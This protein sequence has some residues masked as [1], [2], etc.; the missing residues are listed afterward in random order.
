M[1]WVLIAVLI[2]IAIAFIFPALLRKEIVQD[3]TREQNIAIAREQLEELEQRYKQNEIDQ[4]NYQSVKEELEH[5]LF[6]D[7]KESDL[8]DLDNPNSFSYNKSKKVP[9]KSVDTWLIL[10]LA[11]V[12]A[13]P[14]YL[15]LGNL[16]F[17]KYLDAKKAVVDVSKSSMPLKADGSPDV[18][19]I[20]R[21]LKKEMESNPTDPKGWYM[22]GR[23]YMM[24]NSIPDAVDSF[25][26]SL[27]LRP[28]SA[29]TMLSLADALSMDNEGQLTGKPRELVKKA[30]TIEPQNVTALWL[31]GMAASQE[32]EYQEAI[33]QWQKV[34]PFIDN[35]PEEKNA[36]LGLIEEAQ[37][38]LGDN[39]TNQ[40]TENINDQIKEEASKNNNKS[41]K[42]KITLS[43][44]FTEKVSP[45]DLVF[46]YAKAMNGPPMPLAAAR[47][48]VKEFPIDLI[49]NDEMAMIPNMKLSSYEMVIVGARISKSG[50][51]IASDG[52]LF[53]EKTNISL[54]DSISLEIDQIYKK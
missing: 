49:L 38:R 27:A 2:A 37:K 45:E 24:I 7:I 23:A 19:K 44:E 32:A 11:P 10:I 36:V 48:L 53:T 25:E 40:L 30:L 12:I 16:S 39:G 6:N 17:T 13:V 15:N 3:A 34:L 26:K 18:D 47:R 50:Q 22:L 21:Q 46:V 8:E 4:S 51:A 43:S 29:E 33:S 42:L 31:A 41:I 9:S 20:A 14:V 5:A 28:D 52:D 54:G 35:K 1:F